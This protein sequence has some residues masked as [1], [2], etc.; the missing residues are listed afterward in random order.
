MTFR[1]T[2]RSFA[3][4]PARDPFP[5]LPI[6]PTWDRSLSIHSQTCR[7]SVLRLFFVRSVPADPQETTIGQRPG[8]VRV[9]TFHVHETRSCAFV[10]F[11]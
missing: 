3:A 5:D 2:T 7:N 1:K 4:P 10:R 11:G 6:C 9:P 8:V